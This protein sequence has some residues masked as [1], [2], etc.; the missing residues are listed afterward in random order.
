MIDEY[1]RKV[2]EEGFQCIVGVD[3]AG[4]GPLAGPVIAA[5]VHI[6]FD[7]VIPG[8]D[9]SKKL[10]AKKRSE[11]FH[12]LTSHE[13]IHV[14]IGRIDAEQIDRINILQATFAAMLDAVQKLPISPDHLLIDGHLSPRTNLAKT[15]LVG[16]DGKSRLIGA[17]SIIAKHVRDEIMLEYHKQ[18]PEYGFDAHKG[19]GTKVHLAAIDAYGV[20]PIHRHSFAPVRTAQAKRHLSMLQEAA[21]PGDVS[22]KAHQP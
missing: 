14:G 22:S 3:E 6:P 21:A 1:E 2:K 13:R 5:A 12:L 15:P 10:T 18:W 11:L 16:G 19:Y 4:R 8:I 17:A 7:L 20:L 9:D